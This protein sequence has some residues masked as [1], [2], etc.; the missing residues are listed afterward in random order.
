[1]S[2][3]HIDHVENSFE[4]AAAYINVINIFQ[5]FFPILLRHQSFW[6]CSIKCFVKKCNFFFLTP[7]LFTEFFFG[8]YIYV[9]ILFIQSKQK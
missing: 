8:S 9:Y 7:Y 6:V 5:T 3:R 2:M 1:M 4:Y